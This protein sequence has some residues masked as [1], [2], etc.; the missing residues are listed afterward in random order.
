METGLRAPAGDKRTVRLGPH[1]PRRPTTLMQAPAARPRS[2]VPFPG[3]SGGLG[4]GVVAPVL[5]MRKPRLWEDRGS[6]KVTG[7]PRTRTSEGPV[8]GGVH[9]SGRTGRRKC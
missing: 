3:A 6:S 4:S 5:Q 8:R 1:R 2:G 9:K 7:E